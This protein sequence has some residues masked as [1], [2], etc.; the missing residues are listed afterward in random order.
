MLVSKSIHHTKALEVLASGSHPRVITESDSAEAIAVVSSSAR[1]VNPYL[2]MVWSIR[3]AI[4][5]GVE[6]RFHHVLR[7][8]TLWRIA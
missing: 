5:H 7:R 4:P 3:Q 8:P 1:L 2:E 6:V